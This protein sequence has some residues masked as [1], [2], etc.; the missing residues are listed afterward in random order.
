MKHLKVG[1]VVIIIHTVVHSQI[2]VYP[3]GTA[4]GGSD[5]RFGKFCL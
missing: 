3:G 4:P 5:T 2:Q 1:C